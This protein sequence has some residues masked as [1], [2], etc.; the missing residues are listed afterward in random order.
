MDSSVDMETGEALV[1]ALHAYHL[2]AADG[3]VVEPS[4]LVGS[5]QGA[6]LVGTGI[7]VVGVGGGSVDTL[8]THETL[9]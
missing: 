2:A 8:D 1:N 9:G 6:C 4:G 7:E 3:H 5:E